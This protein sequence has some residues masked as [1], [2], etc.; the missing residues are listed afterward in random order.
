MISL[1]EL[2]K[3]LKQRPRDNFTN[4]YYDD[5]SKKSDRGRY[6]KLLLLKRSN[7]LSVVAIEEVGEVETRTG[8]R[9]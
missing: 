2:R 8:S 4:L 6:E 9:R 1:E 5:R 7:F 3:K